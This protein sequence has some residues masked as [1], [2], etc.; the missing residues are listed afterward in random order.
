MGAQTYLPIEILDYV[1]THAPPPDS[2]YGVSQRELAK[3]LGYHPCSMSRPLDTLVRDGLL[4]ARRGLVRDGQRKQL[5]YLLTPQGFTRLKRETRDVPLLAGEIPA[6]PHPFLG[7][8]DE[9]D[10]LFDISREGGSV[11]FVD[12]A[13]SMGKTALVSR[14]LRRVKQG[15]IPFWFSVHP[16]SSPRLFVTAIAHA[17]SYLGSTQLAYYS[18]LPR[19]PVAREVA[20]L[21]ARALGNRTLVA[22]IDD[23]QVAGGDFR[24]FLAEFITALL[25]GREDQVYLVGQESPFFEPDGLSSHRITVGGLD[26]AAAHELTDRQ[27]GLSDRFEEVYQSTMGSPLLLQLAVQNPEARADAA[28]LPTTLVKRLPTEDVRAILPIALANEPLPRAF[29][30]KEGA[31]TPTR[32]NELLRTGVLHK[33]LQDRV[34][35][36]QV[37]RTALIARVGSTEEREAH[38]LLARFYSRS[39]RPEAVR[40][41]FLHLVEGEAWKNAGN[42]LAQQERMIL[43]LGYSDTLR[44]ALRHLVTSLPRGQLKVRVLV[45]EAAL[46]RLHSD[47]SEAI[48]TLRRA[49]AESNDDPRV[50]AETLLSIVDLYTKLRQLD[51]AHAEFELAK[52]IGPISRRLQ[53]FFLLTEARLAESGGD[54]RKAQALYQ[55]AFELA[56]KY[57]TADLGL[58]SIAA[59]SSLAELQSGPDVAINLVAEALPA[60][61][62][63]GR[64]DVAFN[65][66]LVRARAYSDTGRTDL[67]EADMLAIRSEAESLGYL[68][69]LT[70][71]LS[72]LA[73]IAGEGRRWGEAVSYAKQA[74]ALAER[75]GNDLVLGHTLGVLCATEFREADLGGGAQLAQEAIAHGERSVAIL[76]RLPASDSLVMSHGHLTEAYMY[77]KDLGQARRHYETALSLAESLGLTLLR[78]QLMAELGSKLSTVE[79]TTP[80]ASAPLRET[81]LPRSD[82]G[83]GGGG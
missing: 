77:V 81:E 35:L 73:A 25:R 17:L 43:R 82:A 20:D 24:K 40:E 59:W 64:M 33:T 1:E 66:L 2:A 50:K 42:L 18:Q 71:T 56:R 29:V 23:V 54:K 10:Q 27:G 49:A 37:V 45:V 68:T 3:A 12:G 30:L 48:I 74:S 63:A 51:Q 15:R 14:H 21:A 4:T 38:L 58:E 44:N 6:P 28:T 22:V 67:A 46:L 5:T 80:A 9:L 53:V 62:Q 79:S 65:L 39:R 70:Y 75:L 41:R 19:S 55:D 83:I 57:G 13:P 52:K 32:L 26:R 69:Q 78:E 60:A 47:Y 31:L 34:E 11:T 61:R 36:L 7:R 16:T 76:E 72:G 8:K